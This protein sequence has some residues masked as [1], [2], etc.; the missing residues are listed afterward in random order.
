MRT[1][2]EVALILS[3]HEVVETTST[4]NIVGSVLRSDLVE[5]VYVV[6]TP[7]V[8][9]INAGIL[10]HMPSSAR[11]LI[12]YLAETKCACENKLRHKSMVV[13]SSA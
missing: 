11:I 4:Y 9:R 12:A 5:D 3:F 6:R 1:C 7:V 13:E 2:A 10:S 8:M